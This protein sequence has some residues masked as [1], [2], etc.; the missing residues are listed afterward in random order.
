MGFEIG[1]FTGGRSSH[2]ASLSDKRFNLIS[3]GSS[4]LEFTHSRVSFPEKRHFYRSKR[5][6]VPFEIR[7]EGTSKNL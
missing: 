2:S 5:L 4:E 7:V 6:R 3:V 1:E